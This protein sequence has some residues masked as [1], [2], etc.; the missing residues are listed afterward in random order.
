VPGSE[1]AVD[2][3]VEVEEAVLN[4]AHD[5]E[6]GDRFADG[7]GL[8]DGARSDAGGAAGFE[9]AV[10]ARPGNFAAVD[11]GDADARDAVGGHAF[12]E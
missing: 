1:V 2:V 10:A 9:V 3:F 8:E 4:E 12:R 6:G 11:G 7:G 5:G